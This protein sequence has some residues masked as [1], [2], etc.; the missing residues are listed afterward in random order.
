MLHQDTARTIKLTRAIIAA[1]AA[2]IWMAVLWLSPS[3]PEVVSNHKSTSDEPVVSDSLTTQAEFIPSAAATQ[4][5]PD[6]SGAVAAL[7][8]PLSPYAIK[9]LVDNNPQLDLRPLWRRLGIPAK[10]NTVWPRIGGQDDTSSIFAGGSDQ[11]R[12]LTELYHLELDGAPGNEVLLKLHQGWLGGY[13]RYLVF[14]RRPNEATRKL[15]W[16]FLGYADH[17]FTKYE[18]PSHRVVA[19]AGSR[20][21]V[22]RVQTGSG[23][24]FARYHER[25]YEVSGADVREVL[26]I[27]AS[28]HASSTCLIPTLDVKSRF[29]NYRVANNVEAIKILFSATWQAPCTGRNGDRPRTL[30]IRNQEATYVRRFGGTEYRLDPSRSQINARELDQVYN[31]NDYSEDFLENNFA[32]LSQVIARK[33]RQLTEWVQLILEHSDDSATKQRLLRQLGQ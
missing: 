6:N 10:L 8:V 32:R 28:G 17:D 14:S 22:I 20:W 33:D 4:S 25:W 24:G 3:N 18:Q 1:T 16:K 19:T 13:T 30:W 29:L 12:C 23:S 2:V 27:P 26:T 31:L 11:S 15:K 9:R 5:T 21:L 7:R